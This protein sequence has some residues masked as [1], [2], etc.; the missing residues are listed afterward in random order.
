M[1]AFVNMFVVPPLDENPGDATENPSHTSHPMQLHDTV[2]DR[3]I[4]LGVDSV[5]YHS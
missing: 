4:A 2:S 5:I 1:P 3:Q